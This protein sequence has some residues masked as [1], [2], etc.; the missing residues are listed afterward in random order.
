MKS[1]ARAITM[2]HAANA[3]LETRII[4]AR[5]RRSIRSYDRD[6]HPCRRGRV[7]RGAVATKTDSPGAVVVLP[8]VRHGV[9]RAADLRRWIGRSDLEWSDGPA[10]ILSRVTRALGQPS[11][12]SGR[13]ALRLWG[14]TGDRPTVWMTAADPVYLEPRLDH[15]CL[16]RLAP[17]DIAP[18][19]LT[20]LF[21]ELQQEL[22]GEDGAGFV[23]L[24]RLGYLRRSAPMPT[25]ELSPDALHGLDPAAHMPTG[26]ESRPFHRVHSEIQML[27][28]LS[29]VQRRREA[30]GA[31]PINALWL[32]GG[33]SAPPRAARPIPTLYADDP[34][35]RGY[36]HSAAGTV[37]SFDGRLENCAEKSPEGFVAVVPH[38]QIPTAD[39]VDALSAHLAA[40]RLILGEGAFGSLSLLFKDGVSA[41]V[42]RRHALRFWRRPSPLL[43]PVEA[44]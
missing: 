18:D 26:A 41:R 10:E 37:A 28:H 7:R 40:L 20:E 9:V 8:A 5:D 16:H 14:Q 25:A 23:Q 1:A 35:L 29:P 22:G 3:G 34:L 13:G 43:E 39:G 44:T 15:L 6:R 30:A 27:M 42:R 21:D 12:D 32:W 4:Q 38:M 31:R 36:W 11:V 2:A 19:D 24:G 17:D 33:G